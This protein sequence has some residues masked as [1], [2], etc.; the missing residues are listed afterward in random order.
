MKTNPN[1]SQ[2]IKKTLLILGIVLVIL[3]IFCFTLSS[4]DLSQLNI[5]NSQKRKI[6][7]K[8]SSENN[9][10]R[11][12]NSYLYQQ[13]QKLKNFRNTFSGKKIIDVSNLQSNI[14]NYKKKKRM[15]DKKKKK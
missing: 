8:Y 1:T 12:E 15:L 14:K 7:D 2:I 3:I 4:S 10:K 9:Q 6:T 13:N 5:K 11:K